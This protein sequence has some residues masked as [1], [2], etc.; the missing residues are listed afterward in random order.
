MKAEIITLKI[1]KEAKEE[2]KKVCDDRHSTPSHELRLFIY[3]TIS[4]V[5]TLKH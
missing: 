5:K 4:A 2:F 1:D 3:E